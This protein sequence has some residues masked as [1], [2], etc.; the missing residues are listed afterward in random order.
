[1]RERAWKILYKNTTPPSSNE[2]ILKILFTNRALTDQISIDAFLKPDLSTIDFN[3]GDMDKVVIRLKNAIEDQEKIVVYGDY[4]A[5]GVTATAVMW[6]TLHSLGANVKP[7]IPHREREG[8]GMSIYGID[9]LIET[10]QVQ[11]IVTVDQGIS[12]RNQIAYAR[13]K[14]IDVIVTDHHAAPKLLP[15]DCLIV[16][17]HRVS[18]AAVAWK[19]ATKLLKS[20]TSDTD[21]P[22]LSKKL[23]E[24][25]AIG[26]VCDI[27]PLQGE[28]RTLVTYGLEQLKLSDREGLKAIAK[29][30]AFELRDL[31][32]YHIGYV[33]GPRINA[34]GRLEHAIDSLRL[35]CTKVPQRAEELAK[36]INLVNTDRKEITQA[37]IDEARKQ[38]EE[39]KKQNLLIIGD[40]S[41]NPGIIGLVASRMIEEFYKPTIVWGSSADHNNI[42]KA[43]ARSVKGFNIIDAI[44]NSGEHLISFGGHPMAAGFSLEPSSLSN[45]TKSINTYAKPFMTDDLLTP[46]L[47]IDCELPLTL[48]SQELFNE[49]QQLRPFGAQAD[50]PLFATQDIKVVE[51]RAIGTANKHLKLKLSDTKTNKQYD[52]IAFSLGELNSKIRPGDPIDIA[53]HLDVNEWN[54]KKTLQL[55]IRDIKLKN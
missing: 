30:A 10:E 39:Q 55:K 1:M 26:L 20:S 15:E 53:Y 12:A 18:G 24:L 43:S 50:E 5:D 36:K 4:D 13:S 40:P 41:W 23:L 45:F 6:E 22:P 46:S 48:A 16:H 19:V 9:H 31:Q 29:I 47:E 2:E 27:I 37:L 25:V 14:G 51:S 8:Y 33:I 42:Y 49:I 35:L 21:L 3:V 54:N 44:S 34:T 11:L 7:Y 52:A 28:A 17:D 38:A 32:T